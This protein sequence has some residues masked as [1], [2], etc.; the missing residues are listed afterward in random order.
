MI[1]AENNGEPKETVGADGKMTDTRTG[2]GAIWSDRSG[3]ITK[4]TR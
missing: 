2:T 3:H 4:A 1:W